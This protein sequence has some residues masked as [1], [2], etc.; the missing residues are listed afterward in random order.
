MSGNTT[1]QDDNSFFDLVRLL[2]SST[3][4]R[5]LGFEHSDEF[6]QPNGPVK[7]GHR[8]STTEHATANIR[9]AVTE[10]LVVDQELEEGLDVLWGECWSKQLES[11]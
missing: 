5:E 7:V 8:G 4:A 10:G 2:R 3:S 1:N 9:M 6:R 11:S